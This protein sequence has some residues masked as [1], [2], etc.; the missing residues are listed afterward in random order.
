MEEVLLAQ[1][2]GVEA[3]GVVRTVATPIIMRLSAA[4]TW[5][6]CCWHSSRWAPR[7]RAW[8]ARSRR[9]S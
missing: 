1:Q 7:R 5:K 8:R 6:R 9:R 2:M 3:Q 4:V